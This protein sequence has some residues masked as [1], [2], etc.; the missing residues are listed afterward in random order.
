MSI[1]TNSTKNI[2]LGK[3]LSQ[4]F[5]VPEQFDDRVRHYEVVLD[6]GA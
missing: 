3:K 4:A 1:A 2:D 6:D 5:S